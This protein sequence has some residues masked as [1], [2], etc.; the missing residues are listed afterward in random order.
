MA[1][2]QSPKPKNPSPYG[3]LLAQ[4]QQARTLTIRGISVRPDLVA[5]RVSVSNTGKAIPADAL[6]HLFDKFYR[7][8]GGDRWKQGGT[9]LGLALIKQQVEFLRRL[10]SGKQ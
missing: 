3:L 7:V 1:S 9:G 5:H 8:P 6:P 4:P 2:H 10:H